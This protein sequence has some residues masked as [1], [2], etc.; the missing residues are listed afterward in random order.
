MKNAGGCFRANAGNAFYIIGRV[1]DERFVIQE[2]FR[3]KPVFVFYGG[4]VKVH[5]FTYSFF[6]RAHYYFAVIDHLK[7]IHVARHYYY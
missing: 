7:R 5:S 3:L 2:L 6:E 1:A 4:F